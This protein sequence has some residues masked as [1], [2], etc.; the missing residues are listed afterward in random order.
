MRMVETAILIDRGPSRQALAFNGPDD[1]ISFLESEREFWSWQAGKLDV[2]N[3]NVENLISQYNPAWTEQLKTLTEQW[4]TSTDTDANQNSRNQLENGLRRRFTNRRHFCARDPEAISI[5]AIARQDANVAAVALATL[6]GIAPLQDQPSLQHGSNLAGVARGLA[7]AAGIDSSGAM[8]AVTELNKARQRFEDDT[9]R[10]RSTIED[11]KNHSATLAQKIA[12]DANTQNE[13]LERE[14]QSEEAA[15]KSIFESQRSDYGALKK[16]FEID[17]Q[18][19]G[20]VRYWENKAR[21]HGKAKWISLLFLTIY[22]VIAVLGLIWV[23]DDAASHLPTT[24]NEAISYAAI[25]KAG[26]FALLISSI[27]FWIGRVFLRIYLSNQH[28]QTDAQERMTMAMT[29]LALIRSDSIKDE[30]RKLILAPLF[31]S[32]SDGI[33][34]DDTSPDTALVTLFSNLIKSGR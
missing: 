25:F 34:K 10:L 19:K 13:R 33:V 29:F 23:Y 15:R 24:A 27:A 3:G 16:A 6:H 17:M 30:E 28:L 9:N 7:V 4:R 8:G 18:L 5:S 32:A 20:P 2:N 31:R 1:V 11:T 26:A 12:T 21:R 14:F 22:T